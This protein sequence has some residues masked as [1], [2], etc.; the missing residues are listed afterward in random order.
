MTHFEKEGGEHEH[1]P[2]E[3]KGHHVP[4]HKEHKPH[5]QKIHEY[6]E[7]K[8]H[9]PEHHKPHHRV[10]EKKECCSDKGLNSFQ[11]FLAAAVI[12]QIAL[13]LFIAVKLPDG[14]VVVNTDDG[15]LPTG[16]DN[17]PSA[18]AAAVDMEALIDDDAIEG[19]EDAPVTIVEWSDYECPFCE[20]FYSGTLQQ[21][22]SEY[23]ETGKVKLIYR[24]FPLSFHQN[25]QKAA[26]A[27]ECAGEQDKY[28]EMHDKLFENGV[29]GGVTAFK[30]YAAS[31]GLD[32]A[33]FNTCLDSGAMAGEVRKDFSD[34][35]R[36]GISGTPGFIVNG[37]LI[38][39]AQ[40]FAAFAQV[41]E[42]ELN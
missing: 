32:T 26:E 17:A 27:A 16:V 14:S 24:D 10:A 38:S 37:K 6:H 22:R 5:E 19:D 21:L 36:A 2:S 12:V 34:G 40:P 29:S 13:L 33:E 7:G 8:K 3:D 30:S 31:I 11:K 35:Q 15:D 23:I 25:A 18:A 1:K 39:G 20:K 9:K 28:F 41:I 4:E 42:A